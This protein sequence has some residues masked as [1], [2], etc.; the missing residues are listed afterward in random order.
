MQMFSIILPQAKS[1]TRAALN[2]IFFFLLTSTA[3]KGGFIIKK[4]K[5]RQ[6]AGPL[7]KVS[8]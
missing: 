4:K 6:T 2:S 1:Q 7:N 5:K 8:Y 3:K